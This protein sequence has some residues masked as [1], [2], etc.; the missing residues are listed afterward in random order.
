MIP[1]PTYKGPE[2]VVYFRTA[3]GLSEEMEKNKKIVW[4]VAFYT[5]W[6][7]ACVNFAPIFAQISNEY[8]LDN[9]KFGKVDIG[10]FPEVG[11]DHHV[12]D[13]SFSRQLPTIIIFRNAKEVNRRPF[14]DTK[15]KLQKFF[16]SEDN[17][18]AAFDLNNVYKECKENPIKAIKTK[19]PGA[20]PEDK[21][22]D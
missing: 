13:S 4:V 9:L 22:N 21:K 15:G 16:F 8:H 19:A 10:R 20:K 12:S 6:N 7:P 17:V 5:V 1:E 2:H 14:A 18:K 11:K 3:N